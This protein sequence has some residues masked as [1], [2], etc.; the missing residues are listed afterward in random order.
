MKLV[1]CDICR[2]FISKDN[3]KEV[4]FLFTSGT[5]AIATTDSKDVTHV[6]SPIDW[7]CFEELYVPLSEFKP[8]TIDLI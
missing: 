4:L 5:V 7:D 3:P 1:T 2:T 6:L 8:T